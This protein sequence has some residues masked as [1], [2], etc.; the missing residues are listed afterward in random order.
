MKGSAKKLKN[1]ADWVRFMHRVLAS[2][3]AKKQY[4]VSRELGLP[5][6]YKCQTVNPDNPEGDLI[7][8]WHKIGT[9]MR[10]DF[11]AV[12][13]Q[14][15]IIVETKSCW[16]DYSSDHKWEN[17]L[18]YCT[19][20]YFAAD[21]ATALKIKEDLA[22]KNKKNIGVFVIDTFVGEWNKDLPVCNR[23]ITDC[24]CIQNARKNNPEF[25]NVNDILWVMASRNSGFDRFGYYHKGNVFEKQ[26]HST[27]E[28]FDLELEEAEQAA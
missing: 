11:I 5:D 17:Y 19:K 15:V 12:K 10:A 20:F 21:R 4:A 25:L 9:R 18:K 28:D 13:D 3:F 2:H 1:K 14:D 7:F 23:M 6:Y 26:F 16:S 22:I 24:Y 8:K 27:F